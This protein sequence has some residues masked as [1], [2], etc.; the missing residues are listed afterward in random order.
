MLPVAGIE[1]GGGGP[2]AFGLTAGHLLPEQRR[3]ASA[4]IGKQG[5][6]AN[7]V[8]QLPLGLGAIAQLEGR[9]G[10]AGASHGKAWPSQGGGFKTTARFLPVAQGALHVAE[11]V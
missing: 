11:V 9:Q 3:E 7:Q 10:S 1:A 5:I 8:A 6:A 4:G 2:V